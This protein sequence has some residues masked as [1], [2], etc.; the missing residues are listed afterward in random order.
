MKIAL[1]FIATT[2]L[3]LL[4]LTAQERTVSFNG[5]R[6]LM[7]ALLEIQKATGTPISYE[8]PPYE[9]PTDFVRTTPASHPG[10]RPMLIARTS[11]NPVVVS[12][13]GLDSISDP[14]V[15]ILA[16][17]DAH[18]K[19]GLPGRYKVVR[20][21]KGID[22][23]PI[24]VAGSN[25]GPKAITP[26]MGSP[27]SFPYAERSVVETF[28]LI[29][30][31]MA[32][33]AGRKIKLLNNPFSTDMSARVALSSDGSSIAD[34]LNSLV[35]KIGIPAISYLLAFD[36]NDDCFYLTLT[37]I[38]PS[39]PTGPGTREPNPAVTANPFFAKPKP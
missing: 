16:I 18:H 15:F 32:K 28:Q 9:H 4:P 10:L 31:A 14:T 30:D 35:A 34:A 38:S 26:I 17:V 27:V 24:E 20:R 11:S 1:R 19:A 6:T 8:E 21:Q 12:L 33:A 29:A 39:H 3:I 36:P 13:P 7:A 22:V 23:V 5:P 25:T 37:G 2:F